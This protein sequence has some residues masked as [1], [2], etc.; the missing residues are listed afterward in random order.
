VE[1]GIKIILL[2][3]PKEFPLRKEIPALKDHLKGEHRRR[4]EGEQGEHHRRSEGEQGA[5]SELR[6]EDER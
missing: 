6:S 2:L 1:I 4:S 5:G 3:G